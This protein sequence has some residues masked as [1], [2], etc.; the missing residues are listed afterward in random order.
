[1]LAR[2][3]VVSPE[4]FAKWYS[5]QPVQIAGLAPGTAEPKG[6][7]LLNQKG[8]LS[9]HSLDGTPL[10]GTTF[11]GLFGKEVVVLTKG[12]KRT[13]TADEAYLRASILDSHADIVVGY[14]DVMPLEKGL[15][16][17]E[18]VEEMIGY[19]QQHK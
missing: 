4:Q 5:G 8:C 6:E 9:C 16:S 14:Q 18:E 13:I 2:L 3:I 15:L 10:V 19:L 7:E 17:E 11:K 12:K 1:M